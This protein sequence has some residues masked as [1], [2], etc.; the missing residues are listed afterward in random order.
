MSA[1]AGNLAYSPSEA[2]PALSRTQRRL[3]DR[4]LFADERVLV[5]AA[6]QLKGCAGR[7]ARGAPR[8]GALAVTDRRLL[9]VDPASEHAKDSVI[10][11]PFFEIEQIAYLHTMTGRKVIVC[12]RQGTFVGAVKPE[13][14]PAE[15]LVATL[16][17]QIEEPY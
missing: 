1:L 6:A 7:R 9:V 5:A 4:A 10:A 2:D 11:I 14:E 17:S 3:I 13:C 15:D 16:Q 8:A 12:T